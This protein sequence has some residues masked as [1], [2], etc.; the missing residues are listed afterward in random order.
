MPACL[1]QLPSVDVGIW[2]IAQYFAQVGMR[3]ISQ[4][5]RDLLDGQTVI[6]AAQQFSG[7]AG[8]AAAAFH[9]H[10]PG[11]SKNSGCLAGQLRP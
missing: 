10:P 11:Q 6:A 8:V 3:Y 4:R 7:L 1:A 5:L 9:F 2:H